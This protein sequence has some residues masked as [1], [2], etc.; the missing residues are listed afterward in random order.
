MTTKAMLLS[1][2][3]AAVAGATGLEASEVKVN[4]DLI[5]THFPEIAGELKAEGGKDA[6]KNERD[7]IATIQ[8]AAF[9]G[10]EELVAKLIADGTSAGEAAL[11]LNAAAKQKIRDAQASIVNNDK[12]AE[13]VKPSPAVTESGAGKAGDGLTGE[14]KYKAE[15]AADA[16]LQAEFGDEKSYIAFRR[17]E[18][19]KRIKVLRGKASA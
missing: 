15:W 18:D 2:V 5:K 3:A 11:A 4:A 10:Q 12:L 16:A 14:A 8:A 9:K 17:A 13:G 19:A 6:A 1:A 7:R